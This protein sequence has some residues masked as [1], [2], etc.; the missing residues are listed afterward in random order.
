MPSG[1]L[2]DL[3]DGRPNPNTYGYGHRDLAAEENLMAEQPEPGAKIIIWHPEELFAR[4]HV[5]MTRH[6]E[7]AGAIDIEKEL[8]K[9]FNIILMY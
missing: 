1:L 6:I 5:R 8:P 7:L 3:P 2:A 4:K 9:A